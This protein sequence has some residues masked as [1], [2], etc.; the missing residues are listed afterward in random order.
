ME[1][2]SAHLLEDPVFARGGTPV[3]VT[4]VPTRMCDVAPTIAASVVKASNIV[5]RG[6]A[7][8]LTA[9]TFQTTSKPASSARRHRSTSTESGWC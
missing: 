5:I 4:N 3:L 1:L 7:G 8:S 2:V 6:W 9:S